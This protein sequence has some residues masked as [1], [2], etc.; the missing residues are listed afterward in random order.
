MSTLQADLRRYRSDFSRQDLSL[1]KLLGRRPTLQVI[2]VYRLGQW[3]RSN[4]RGIR[5]WLLPVTWLIYTPLHHLLGRAYGI[6]LH[7]SAD[8]GPG[9]YI[10]HGGGIE[11]RD[12]TIGAHCSIAQQTTIGPA[13]PGERGPMIGSRVWIGAH[14][15]VTGPIT[16]GHG[17]TIAAGAHVAR[18]VPPGS[19]AAG[20]PARLVKWFYDNAG[21]LGD[22]IGGTTP[23]LRTRKDC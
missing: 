2:A 16:V 5:L 17:A 4:S 13:A 23:A 11:V 10:G 20:N 18:D 21:I 12:C 19:L 1:L 14:A 3:L 7:A 15:R 8:I 6:R 9:L 22:P